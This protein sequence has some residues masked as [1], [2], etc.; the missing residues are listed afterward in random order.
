MIR[1]IE[2]R[3]YRCLR[4]VR[5]E[6]EPFQIL[7]GPN[8]SGKSTFLDVVAFIGDLLRNGLAAA[9]RVRSPNVQ[10]LVWM[11]GWGPIDLAVELEIPEERRTRLPQNGGVRARYEVALGLDYG[12]E[13]SI[14]GENL[15]L[16]PPDSSRRMPTQREFFPH[17]SQPT[18]EIVL[19]EGKH[20]PKG[21]KKI[22]TKNVHSGIDYFYAET[23]GWKSP[24]R[25]GPQKLALANLPEDE[26]R[27]PVAI[28]VKRLLMEGVQRV[29]L[30]S[31]AMRKPSPP[32]SPRD[33]QPDGSSLPWAIETLRHSPDTFDRWLEHVRTALPDVQSIETVERPEDKHRYMQV[34]YS[35]GL[36]APS[37]SV[38]DG[39]LRLLALTLIAYLDAPDRIYLVEEPENGIHPQA[40]ETVFQSL[41]SAYR[42]QILCASHSPVM[43]S[44]AEP[45]Q[46]LCF[47]RN[48]EGAT[49]IVTGDEH[50]NLRDWKRG[51]DLGTLFATGVLG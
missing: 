25:L 40:V 3:Q 50:P 31:D 10:N 45:K 44:L 21:W 13:L 5:R 19:A 39:T 12:G 35:T 30:N 46:V 51:A 11:E 29:A 43:L 17:P 8:A 7:V 6:L 34:V 1:L 32:G 20:A 28:W 4:Y 47:A 16:K 2:A 24:F 14:R 48:A 37:W 22:V 23:S 41:S 38:S 18:H 9:V 33:F 26:E 49:D 42:Q 27:F 36:K 15:W